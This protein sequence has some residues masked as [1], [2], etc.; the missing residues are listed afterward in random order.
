MRPTQPPLDWPR[1][2]ATC[3]RVSLA[4]P[5]GLT[6]ACSQSQA[7]AA[8]PEPAPAAA[9]A[10]PAGQCTGKLPDFTNST[11]PPDFA[12][13][14]PATETQLATFAWQHFVALNWASSYAKN[15]QRGMPDTAT[16][17]FGQAGSAQP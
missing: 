6:L 3:T 2:V 11:P 7:P 15:Q 8:K 16:T 12:G 10:G 1:R 4:L 5:L 14:L 13:S 9:S 17:F